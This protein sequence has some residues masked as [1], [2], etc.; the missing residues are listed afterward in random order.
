MSEIT[1]ITENKKNNCNAVR[2]HQTFKKF[3]KK[4]ENNISL[5][6]LVHIIS[7][8]LL[9]IINLTADRFSS[10]TNYEFISIF[11]IYI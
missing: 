1:E 6:K 2:I 4:K 7:I 11:I 3:I 8:Q 5:T 10:R 9:S